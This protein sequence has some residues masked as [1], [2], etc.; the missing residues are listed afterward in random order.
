MGASLGGCFFW[1]FEMNRCCVS[2]FND[3]VIKYVIEEDGFVDNCSYCGSENVK[4]IDVS[5]STFLEM[6]EIFNKIYSYNPVRH[7]RSLIDIFQ[8]EWNVFSNGNNGKED[9][10]KDIMK[11]FNVDSDEYFTINPE[12]VKYINIWQQYSRSIKYE[13]RFTLQIPED[14]QSILIHGFD[15]RVKLLK[16]GQKLYRARIGGETNEFNKIIAPYTATLKDM[17]MPP[18]TKTNIGR[19]NPVGIPYLY[20]ADS[21]ETAI[22]E[23]RPWTGSYVTLGTMEL[24]KP[25]RI[26]DLTKSMFSSLMI[27]FIDLEKAIGAH[28]LIRNLSKELSKPVDPNTSNIEYLPTQFLTE[29][30]KTKGF[31]GIKFKSSLG[32][33][34]NIVLFKQDDIEVIDTTLQQIYNIHYSFFEVL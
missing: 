5:N 10:L 21:D 2:C 16:S 23:V 25:K 26:I 12:Y 20:V 7:S 31:D 34:N 9:L 30:I 17:G 8:W 11:S 13:N 28:E 22:A 4:C 33:G 29:Y 15:H 18:K 6:F 32:G 14:L 27:T 1:R 19:A 3:E 24:K